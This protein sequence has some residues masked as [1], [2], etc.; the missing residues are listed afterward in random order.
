MEVL[1]SKFVGTPV[2]L[3]NG[4][5]PVANLLDLVIDPSTG[6]IA[7]FS[8]ASRFQKVISPM[9]VRMWVNQIQIRDYEDIVPYDDIIQVKNIV[10]KQIPILGNK[11]YS[12]EG[13]YL[14]K[15]FDYA[16]HPQMMILKKIFVAKTILGLI[17]LHERII[18]Y[19]CIYEIMREKI[20]VKT[21]NEVFEDSTEAKKALTLDP[22]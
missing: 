4:G 11:V 3:E 16:V 20:I 15:V 19:S 7:A 18:P 2:F 10:D 5:R 13:E 22:A 17:R 6:K 14:G 8:V 9:D 21:D 12:Q 1:H